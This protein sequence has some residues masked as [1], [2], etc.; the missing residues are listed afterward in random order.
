MTSDY[1]LGFV[2]VVLEMLRE[3]TDLEVDR[4]GQNLG[5]GT[6]VPIHASMHAPHTRTQVFE[7]IFL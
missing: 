5:I 4:Q 3:L 7:G 6:N 2:V 1:D